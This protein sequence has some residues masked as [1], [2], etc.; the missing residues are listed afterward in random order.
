MN[1]K[2]KRYIGIFACVSVALLLVLVAVCSATCDN[3]E[4]VEEVAETV[5]TIPVMKTRAAQ[6]SRL[7]TAEYQMRKIVVFD[8]P[9]ALTGK[10]FHQNFSV[11][12]PLGK[13]RIAIPVTATAKAYVDMS[14]VTEDDFHRDGDRLEI[15]LPDPE[16]MLTATQIDHKGVKQKVALLRS[17]FT[18]DEITR[19]QQQGR[20]DIIKQL[21]SSHILEDARQ[22]AARQLVPIAVSMGF[23]EENVTVTFRKDF[24]VSDLPKL[25]RELN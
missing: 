6:C 20:K 16:V 18:D 15:V 3:D 23:K 11:D 24:K 25:I 19:I 5:D 21:T 13:R 8:D 7:Y 1:K 14:K 22:S 2:N 9:A 10:I 17:D 12:L 4:S